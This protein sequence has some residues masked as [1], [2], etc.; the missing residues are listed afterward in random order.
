MVNYEKMYKTLFNG[1]TDALRSMDQQN[2][3]YAKTT[4]IEH[5]QK[6]EDFFIASEEE[7]VMEL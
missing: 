3:D 5:Q 4:L 6:T 1:V 7:P 2:Y